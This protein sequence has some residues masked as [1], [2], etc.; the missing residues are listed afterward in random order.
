MD[1]QGRKLR[2]TECAV[3]PFCIE[4][5]PSFLF[6]RDSKDN[7]EL[8]T[9]G[10]PLNKY[11]SSVMYTAAKA[12]LG[13]TF[14]GIFYE[15]SELSEEEALSRIESKIKYDFL[16]HPHLLK[17][18]HTLLYSATKHQVYYAGKSAGSGEESKHAIDEHEGLVAYFNPPLEPYL[19]ENLNSL[20]AKSDQYKHISFH[21]AT[22]TEIISGKISLSE[23]TI[24]IFSRSKLSL[25]A[26][27]VPEP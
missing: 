17:F 6:Y 20:L 12:F 21:W 2:F 24:E 11:D 22:L 15:L 3:F 18:L 27:L 19:V 23:N 10:S 14:D 7:E 1:L 9:F 13:G 16:R 26:W 4:P 25:E 5:E 8:K